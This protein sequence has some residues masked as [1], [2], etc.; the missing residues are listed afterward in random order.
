VVVLAVAVPS[1][2]DFT[3][4]NQLAATKSSF[5]AALG[6]ARSEAARRGR[7]VVL[8]ALGTGPSGNEFA[9]GWEIAIDDDGSGSVAT[10]E[11]R[12]RKN[13]VNLQRVR[14]TGTPAVSFR[15][16]GA[17]AGTTAQVYTLCRTGGTRGFT[18]TVMP[19]GA[20]DVAELTTCTP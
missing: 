6:L 20:T 11:T 18:V 9:N 15:A 7:L 19:S 2:Q 12:V 16:T 4:H 17:L 14:L 1:M 10:S 8:Q 3:A 5:T 13:T